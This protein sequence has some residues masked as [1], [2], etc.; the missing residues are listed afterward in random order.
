MFTSLLLSFALPQ[1]ETIQPQKILS[2]GMIQYQ[3]LE[4]Q[5]SSAAGIRLNLAAYLTLTMQEVN[6]PLGTI[7]MEMLFAKPLHGHMNMN[8]KLDFMGQ[9]QEI[10]M[11]SLGDG[12]TLWMLEHE[13][14]IAIPMGE[15]FSS[16][17]EALPGF[18]PL[19]IWSGNSVQ[20]KEA[21]LI[22][23][24]KTHPG[25]QGLHLLTSEGECTLWFDQ[26]DRLKHCSIASGGMG[27]PDLEIVVNSLDWLSSK[28]IDL[29]SLAQSPPE[30]FHILEPED[31]FGGDDDADFTKDLLAVGK[32]VPAETTFTR[33]DDSNA[34]FASL[35]GK[36]V[37]VNFWFYH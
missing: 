34:S 37:L 31:A 6:L 32:A 20:V 13:D 8:G 15:D 18:V 16:I 3:K 19:L 14:Q 29:K 22:E 17:S 11:T 33:M 5:W 26:K 28:Q 25:L 10:S 24:K 30:N 35:R 21:N 23:D 9:S 27:E 2:H 36:T 1:A 12:E 7:N 4:K